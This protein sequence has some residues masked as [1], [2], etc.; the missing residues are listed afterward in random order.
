MLFF[1]RLQLTESDIPNIILRVKLKLDTLKPPCKTYTSMDSTSR[2]MDSFSLLTPPLIFIVIQEDFCAEDSKKYPVYYAHPC[3]PS[4]LL[5]DLDS[6]GVILTA[7]AKHDLPRSCYT[8]M[9]TILPPSPAAVL[10]TH[11][12]LFW[13]RSTMAMNERRKTSAT[14]LCNMHNCGYIC[15][16]YFSF[17]LLTISN[18]RRRRI[19]APWIMSNLVFAMCTIVTHSNYTKK[20]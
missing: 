5:I 13:A 18:S 8:P 6:P 10:S 16:R 14:R 12:I 15:W 19:L 1:E 20:R 2:R 17:W 11:Q 4:P 9:T 3:Y 7:A